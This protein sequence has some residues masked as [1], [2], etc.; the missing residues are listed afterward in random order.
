MGNGMNDKDVKKLKREE[1]LE[2]LIMQ[3]KANE[4][5]QGQLD[6]VKRQLEDKNLLIEKSGSIAEASYMLNGLFDAAQETVVQYLLNT[7]RE[8]PVMAEAPATAEKQVDLEELR[9][10]V[11]ELKF[12][13]KRFG[14]YDQADVEEKF[15]QMVSSYEHCIEH[16][17]DTNQA[18]IKECEEKIDVLQLLTKELS[19]RN[20][21]LRKEQKRRRRR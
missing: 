17:R 9:N 10:R 21:H 7:C 16:E 19:R 13:K 2:L 8:R 20:Y 18:K 15:K 3:K 14:G 11:V 4:E 1:L 6:A 5:L 12:K